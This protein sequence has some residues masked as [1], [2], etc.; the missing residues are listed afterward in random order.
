MTG[1][2]L[3]IS[4]NTNGN[5]EIR[6]NGKGTDELGLLITHMTIDF[7]AT[8]VPRA[9]LH[10]VFP[11]GVEIDDDNINISLIEEDVG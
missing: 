3:Q 11:N 1:S 9:T 4:K 8:D 5:H 10:V 7:S 6:I 2:K